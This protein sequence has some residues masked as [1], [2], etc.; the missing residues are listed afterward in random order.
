MIQFVDRAIEEFLRARVPLAANAVD[1][2]FHAPDKTWGAGLTRPTLNVFLWD[3]ASAAGYSKT[4]LQQRV[5]PT[6][7]VERRPTNPVVDLGYLVTAWAT[8]YRDEHELLGSVLQCVL[9]N[10]ALP[11]EF[12]PDRFAG[13]RCG[14]SLAPGER[15]VPGEFWSALDGRLKPGLQLQVALPVEVFA[16]QSA[17]APAE[18][19]QLTVDPRIPPAKGSR[20]EPQAGGRPGETP[21]AVTPEDG[22]DAPDNGPTAPDLTRRRRNGAIV[23]E[24]RSSRKP[25]TA[26]PGR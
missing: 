22:T 6:G 11:E 17:A 23:M 26:Q 15:R 18:Q 1:V 25:P 12:L 5:N 16:W 8:E 24:A 2:S 14:L 13:L 20:S 3:V 10:K 4:G 19:V 9:A 7:N 21:A